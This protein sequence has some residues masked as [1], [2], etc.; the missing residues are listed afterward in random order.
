[1]KEDDRLENQNGRGLQ[2]GPGLQGK[3]CPKQGMMSP[4]GKSFLDEESIF[5]PGGIENS[6]KGGFIE[7]AIDSNQLGAA[8]EAFRAMRKLKLEKD[9]T[10]SPAEK[11]RLSP[12][13]KDRLSTERGNS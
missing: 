7:P 8:N 12:T 9:F 2:Q 10:K 3:Q 1:M 6:S 5:G 11:D 13:E 4:F